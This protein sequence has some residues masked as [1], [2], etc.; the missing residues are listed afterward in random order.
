[1]LLLKLKTR[2]NNEEC[3]TDTVTDVT[4]RLIAGEIS[5][6]SL[7]ISSVDWVGS[8]LSISRGISTKRYFSVA[9]SA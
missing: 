5:Y 1:M 4:E 7:P 6:H 8:S 3:T 2:L 9:V